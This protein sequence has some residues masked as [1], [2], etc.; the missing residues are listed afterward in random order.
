MCHRERRYQQLRGLGHRDQCARVSEAMPGIAG[1]LLAQLAEPCQR[2]SFQEALMLNHLSFFGSLTRACP[3]VV[4][5]LLYDQ[6]L[7]SDQCR[8][9]SPKPL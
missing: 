2:P 6:Q 9:V 5:Q 3:E 8:V 1:L 4:C 7:W